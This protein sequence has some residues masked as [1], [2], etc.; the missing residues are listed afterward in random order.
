MV[1]SSLSACSKTSLAGTGTEGVIS[2]LDRYLRLGR[3]PD[4]TRLNQYRHSRY[5][6]WL[7]ADGPGPTPV[8]QLRFFLG[9]LSESAELIHLGSI[10]AGQIATKFA[11]VPAVSSWEHYFIRR[12]VQ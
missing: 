12:C 8:L 3:L 5:R 11:L 4:R 9:R 1:K 7:S 2:A 10:V 6:S